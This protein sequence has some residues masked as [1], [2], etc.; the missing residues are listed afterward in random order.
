MGTFWWLVDHTKLILSVLFLWT[1]VWPQHSGAPWI[2]CVV[3]QL[4][5]GRNL[6]RLSHFVCPTTIWATLL[7]MHNNV[8]HTRR[9]CEKKKLGG[10]ECCYLWQNIVFTS[11]DLG[12]SF[13]SSNLPILAPVL[14]FFL[15]ETWSID[16]FLDHGS[17]PFFWLS[18]GFFFC[19][20]DDDCIFS[21]KTHGIRAT[22]LRMHNNAVHTRR[23]CDRPKKILMGLGAN[24]LF[25]GRN[26]V[27]IFHHF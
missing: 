11:I 26:S 16:F 13:H 9:T 6:V 19:A 8:V 17:T 4:F 23:T 20:L 22:L 24:L 15:V 25:C 14:Y 12:L 3:S 7:R 2:F 27:H 5:P 1:A 10:G 21:F 18:M